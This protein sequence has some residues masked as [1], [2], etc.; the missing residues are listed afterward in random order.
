MVLFSKQLVTISLTRQG[1]LV[2][3]RYNSLLRNRIGLGI[4]VIQKG[5]QVSNGAS[6]KSPVA[7]SYWIVFS[8][9]C[10]CFAKLRVRFKPG[11]ELRMVFSLECKL[12]CQVFS[13]G[14]QGF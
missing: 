9:K 13:S 1:M 7:R 12:Q 14:L 10:S 5:G 6:F 11:S 8:L 3:C 2:Y 4:M